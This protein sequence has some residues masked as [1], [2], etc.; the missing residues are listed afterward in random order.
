MKLESLCFIMKNFK[1]NIAAE[2]LICSIL[3]ALIFGVIFFNVP[4]TSICNNEGELKTTTIALLLLSSVLLAC[5]TTFAASFTTKKI[6]NKNNGALCNKVSNDKL[7]FNVIEAINELV[8]NPN[9]DVATVNAFSKI[10][11]SVDIDRIVLFKNR[12]DK[13]TNKIY[14]NYYQEWI[15]DSSYTQLPDLR[16]KDLPLFNIPAIVNTLF[17]KKPLIANTVDLEPVM[18]EILERNKVRSIMLFPIYISDLFWGYVGFD[19]CKKEKVWTEDEKAVLELFATSI[20]S[21]IERKQRREQEEAQQKRE[22]AILQNITDGLIEVDSRCI[23]KYVNPSVEEMFGYKKDELVNKHIKVLFPTEI[24]GNCTE[25]TCGYMSNSN[26]FIRN[27]LLNSSDYKAIKRNG[28][29]F[30]IEIG[31]REYSVE[32]ELISLIMVHNVT[33]RKQAEQVKNEFISTVSHEL[34]TPLTSIQGSLGLILSN[35]FGILPEKAT[36]LLKIANNNSSRLLNLIND[37]L[38][39]EKIEAGKMNFDKRVYEL[40]PIIEEAVEG[41]K[42]Y[43]EKYKVYFEVQSD[44][45]NAKAVVD[46]NRLIQVIT[47]L[48]SNAAKFSPEGDIVKISATQIDG[49]VR[50]SVRDNGPG[51]PE[52]FKHRIFEKFSQVN[53]P[54]MKAKGGTGLGLSICKVIIENLGGQIA[55]DSEPGKGSVFYFD[56]PEYIE[57]S[58]ESVKTLENYNILICEDDQDVASLIE[59]LLRDTNC[60]VHIAKN[61]QEA[62]N[63]LSLNKYHIITLDLILPDQDETFMLNYL[64]SHDRLKNLPI[65]VVS[66]RPPGSF[67]NDLLNKCNI[68]GWIE[69]PINHVKLIDLIKTILK[70]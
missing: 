11:C 5:A 4:E 15:S 44:I 27:K 38:D 62:V 13:E 39:I 28:E 14:T 17:L 22:T 10:A 2:I 50:I 34:R 32:G 70:I 30:Y 67:N 61:A 8:K 36:E 52:E 31:L 7:L 25:R 51:F 3:T 65:V 33:Q 6:I 53:S 66:V 37:I 35:A 21:I 46:K 24:C 45:E 26:C 49:K 9:F 1:K 40:M 42:A 29:Q 64:S 60:N 55:Y 58:E 56:L 16:L 68:M 12:Y 47:N 41:N 59:I 57:S 69:K 18:R 63:L 48:L 23:I 54:E 19:D 20:T 43:A